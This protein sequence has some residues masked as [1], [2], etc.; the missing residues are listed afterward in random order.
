MKA[1]RQQGTASCALP[2]GGSRQATSHLFL[3]PHLLPGSTPSRAFSVCVCVC[4]RA[5]A[6][7]RALEPMCR[8]PKERVPRG[9]GGQGGWA[10]SLRTSG[11]LV[12]RANPMAGLKPG[13]GAWNPAF[14]SVTGSRAVLA[15]SLPLSWPVS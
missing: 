11:R 5:R 9:R 4:V 1:S 15:E 7:T 12:P 13:L 6:H 8:C 2:T 3:P 14:P 10:G